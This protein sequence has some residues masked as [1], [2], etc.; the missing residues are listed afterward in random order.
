MNH[1]GTA[2]AC[3][4]ENHVGTAALGCPAEQSSA[5]SVS[6]IHVCPPNLADQTG[7]CSETG[8]TGMRMPRRQVTT[9]T[10]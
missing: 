8:P 5:A 9:I 2:T 6:P 3:P 4:A 1:V 7:L 10:V